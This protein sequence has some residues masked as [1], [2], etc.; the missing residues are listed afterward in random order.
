ME[1][2]ICCF[3]YNF[4]ILYE[5]A[6]KNFFWQGKLPV[7]Y[8]PQNT[9][10]VFPVPGIHTGPFIISKISACMDSTIES[11]VLGYFYFVNEWE[12]LTLSIIYKWIFIKQLYIF[13]HIP[14]CLFALWSVDVW[15]WILANPPFSVQEGREF[16]KL[17]G[18]QEKKLKIIFSILIDI[19]L[20]GS[21]TVAVPYLRI[22]G[23]FSCTSCKTCL[24]KLFLEED[25]SYKSVS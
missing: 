14:N 9:A 10:D 7:F 6:I 5:K 12:I 1:S 24:E 15:S 4:L 25:D 3:E 23:N 11:V 20:C 17:G 16:T 18:W 13:C 21:K 19:H 2:D 22:T 8:V